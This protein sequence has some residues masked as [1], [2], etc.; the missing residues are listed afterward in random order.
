MTTTAQRGCAA[1]EFNRPNWFIWPRRV[2]G[3]VQAC[4]LTVP[5]LIT[6]ALAERSAQRPGCCID[7]VAAPMQTRADSQRDLRVHRSRPFRQGER[8]FL[9][10]VPRFFGLVARARF[11][12][13]LPR[14]N[15]RAPSKPET[16]AVLKALLESGQLTPIIA[17]TFPLREV[18]AAMRYLQEGPVRGRILITP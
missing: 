5:P 9:G 6:G 16:M 18:P 14:R 15:Q 12:D 8:R 4:S 2:Q 11:D 13:H 1:D 17:G 10:S 7:S 3:S